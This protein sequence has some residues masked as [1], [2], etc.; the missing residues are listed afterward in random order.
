[1]RTKNSTFFSSLFEFTKIENGLFTQPIEQI[2][3][4]SKIFPQVVKLE[5]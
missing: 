2:L 5:K 1:M 4:T 3:F